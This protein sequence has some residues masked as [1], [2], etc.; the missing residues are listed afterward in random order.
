MIMDIDFKGAETFGGMLRE[1]YEAVR[2]ELRQ[3]AVMGIRAILEQVM[4][5]NIG[6]RGSFK[7]NLEALQEAGYISLI[8]FD[9]LDK[10]LEAGHAVTHR[11]FGNVS[12][13]VPRPY[14]YDP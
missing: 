14:G 7:A 6:D 13:C 9:A 5:S 8:Q 12:L 10:V 2:N 11:N 3:L 4:I 1:V